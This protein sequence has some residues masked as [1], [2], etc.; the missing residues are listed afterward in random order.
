M[1]V[2]FYQSF[3]ATVKTDH[4]L[5]SVTGNQHTRTAHQTWTDLQQQQKR[6]LLYPVLDDDLLTGNRHTEPVKGPPRLVATVEKDLKDDEK[7][8]KMWKGVGQD[9]FLKMMEQKILQNQQAVH[10]EMRAMPDVIAFGELDGGH[11]DFAHMPRFAGTLIGST[12]P[13]IKAC[14]SFTVYA[15]NQPNVELAGDGNGWY[16]IRYLGIVVVFVH[17]PNDFAGGMSTAAKKKKTPTVHSGGITKSYTTHRSKRTE[18]TDL[19][20][21]Y[22]RIKNEIARVGKGQIDVIMGDTNQSRLNFTDEVVSIAL[23]K[24]FKN[25]SSRTLFSPADTYETFA[26]GTNSGQDK[27]FDVVVY[28]EATVTV[29]KLC[30]VTQQAPFRGN[31]QV[32]AVTDHMGV[33]VKIEKVS[34]Q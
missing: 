18:V 5:K 12:A 15:N 17:V 9:E 28:N 1:P 32:A 11:A 8:T 21:F 31:G 29:D 4:S 10:R 13:S 25:A 7:Q 3:E 19:V 22:L 24:T 14:H 2:F 16:A 27:M 33:A 6:T 26:K 23:G 20:A 34:A 30:Y